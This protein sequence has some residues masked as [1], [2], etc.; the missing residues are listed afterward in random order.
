VTTVMT[1]LSCARTNAPFSGRLKPDEVFQKVQKERAL[2]HGALGNSQRGGFNQRSSS[3][4]LGCFDN[5]KI[6]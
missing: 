2:P 3:E 4:Y 5:I 6:W 1:T